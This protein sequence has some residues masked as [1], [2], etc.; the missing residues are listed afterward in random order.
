MSTRTLFLSKL[1]GLYCVLAALSMFTHKRAT[2]KTV[3]ALV[4]NPPVLFIAGVNT[5]VA[6]LAMIVSHNVWSGGVLPVV[7]TLVGWL[8]LI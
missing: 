4:H 8:T 1:L 2:V 3:T 5:F 6:G 7:V